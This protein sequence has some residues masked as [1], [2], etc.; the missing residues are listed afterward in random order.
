MET[1]PLSKPPPTLKRNFMMYIGP[2]SEPQGN[3]TINFCIFSPRDLKFVP[4]FTSPV[5]QNKAELRNSLTKIPFGHVK[6]LRALSTKNN[7]TLSKKRQWQKENL[8]S[9]R[10]TRIGTRSQ[11]L[12]NARQ[13]NRPELQFNTSEATPNC[14]DG[15][16]KKDDTGQ[17]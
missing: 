17:Q 10:R 16:L 15:K 6:S 14:L 4:I 2:T 9:A 12:R 1:S 5:S 7:R 3:Y 11:C 8:G 13:K